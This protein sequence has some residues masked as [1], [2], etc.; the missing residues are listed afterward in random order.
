MYIVQGGNG[1]LQHVLEVRGAVTA[2]TRGEG[3]CHSMYLRGGGLS[4]HVLKGRGAVT[5]QMKY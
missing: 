3:G 4:Q 5:V 2:C 1:L